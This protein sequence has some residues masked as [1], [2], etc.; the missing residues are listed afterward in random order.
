MSWDWI[1]LGVMF[2]VVLGGGAIGMAI[3]WYT[4]P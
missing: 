3:L 2:G 4:R 1:I